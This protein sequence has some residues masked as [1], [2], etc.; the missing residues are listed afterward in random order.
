MAGPLAQAH[1]GTGWFPSTEGTWRTANTSATC[2][3]ATVPDVEADR[4]RQQQTGARVNA[5]MTIGVGSK[6]RPELHIRAKK[7]KARN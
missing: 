6:A 5:Q 4:S 2:A 3:Y 7:M 1:V